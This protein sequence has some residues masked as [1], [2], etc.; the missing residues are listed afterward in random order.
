MGGRGMGMPVARIV[1]ALAVPK[2]L[3]PFDL[4]LINRNNTDVA[5]TL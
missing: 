1:C 5:A 2:L 3:L 4:C